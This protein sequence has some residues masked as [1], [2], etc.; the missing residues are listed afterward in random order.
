[1][2]PYHLVVSGAA[3]LMVVGQPAQHLQAGDIVVLAHGGAHR[4]EHAQA[5]TGHAQVTATRDLRDPPALAASGL[6]A[7]PAGVA[8]AGAPGMTSLLRLKGNAGT[9]PVTDI[10][11]G[12]FHFEAHTSRLLLEALPDVIVVRTA[13]RPD[14][15]GLHSL[16][17]MLREEADAMRAGAGAVVA[18]LASALFA[19]VMRAW[20]E[21][22]AAVP[23]LFALL[24]QPRLQPGLQAMLAQPAQPWSL[25]QLARL[26]H[27]SRAT[28]ARL[29]REAAGATPGEV[30]ARTRMAE[31][32]RRLT[33]GRE[34]VAAIGEAVG[35]RSE[36]AFN[37]IFKRCLGVGPGQYRRSARLAAPGSASGSVPL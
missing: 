7:T 20:L 9:G 18:S 27:M 35:Y 23:G 2:A 26:C 33:Q 3:R 10:L 22:A 12:Q 6:L 28:F 29:F 11:C 25:E 19:L 24:A 1:V 8:L 5:A 14:F 4:L 21:Q 13:A 37:R 15:A 16:V 32:A 17:A 34:A 30:L 31:A 36:A